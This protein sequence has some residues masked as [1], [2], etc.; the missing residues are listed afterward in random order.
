MKNAR[1]LKEFGAAIGLY[2]V[3]VIVLMPLLPMMPPGIARY[4]VALLPMVP[5]ILVV[6]AVVRQLGR[7]DELERK[8]QLEALGF[9]FSGTA[10][11]TLSFGFLENAGLPRPSWVFV[12]P[13][14]GLLWI[15]GTALATRKYR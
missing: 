9:G 14:M 11:I 3:S 12:W 15:V 5:A 7:M 13:I 10:I 2:T 8:I 6:L 1:Y 4:L